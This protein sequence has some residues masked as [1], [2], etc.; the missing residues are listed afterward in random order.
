MSKLRA[1][2]C[3]CGALRYEITSD[4]LATAMCY[5]T[6]CQTQSGSAFSMTLVVSA[7]S[8]AF[9]R[10]EPKSYGGRSDSGA[11]KE[12][13]FCADCGVRI[14]NRFPIRPDMVNLK[15]GTLDDPS[16]VAP[17]VAVW[18]SSK[19]PW[20]PIPDGIRQFEKNPG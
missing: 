2:G 15:P 1:G 16:D 4:P 5:C 13:L 8:F 14:C 7:E 3:E 17:M 6:Q 18:T 10:G 20:A 11:D 9:T 12:M 19:P